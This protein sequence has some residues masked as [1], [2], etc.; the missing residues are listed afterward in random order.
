MQVYYESPK[1]IIL[2]DETRST[3]HMQEELR[4]GKVMRRSTCKRN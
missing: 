2:K 3:E 4:E 1:V